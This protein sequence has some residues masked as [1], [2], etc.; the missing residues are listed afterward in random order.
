MSDTQQKRSDPDEDSKTAVTV[1]V[2]LG[3]NLVI[4]LAKLLGGLFANSPALLS[5]AA[6]SVADSINEV[7]LLAS[8]KRSARAPDAKHP[9]GYGKERYFWSLLAAVGIFVMGGCFSFFQGIEAL[10]SGGS[11]T[12]DGYVVVLA[13][14]AVALLAEGSS[15][16]RALVQIRG[17][18]RHASRG[19]VREIR[20]GDD[21]ALRTVL[22]EDSTACLGVVL[23]IA[24]VGLHMLTGNIAYEAWASLLIGALLVF[25]AFQLASQSRAQ[26]IGE[27]A[28]PVLRREIHEF[29]DEQ[30]EIDTVTTLLTMRLGTRSTLVA[31]RVDLVGGM[32]SEDVEEVLVRIKSDMTDRWPLA[33]QVFLDV[34]EATAK[35]RARAAGERRELDATVEAQEAQEAQEARD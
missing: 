14:L 26:L 31:V 9:F 12:R 30:R 33:D 5:E 27:A 8:L 19:M 7:F 34:T 11:E 29:L 35:D 10:R 18:A 20:A 22:A 25:V 24:G 3:A 32:D 23:A 15:L 17:N 1:Y 16:V 4:A 6:H 21:P 2:A 28:D 13:V